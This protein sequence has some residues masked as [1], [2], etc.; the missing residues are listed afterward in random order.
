MSCTSFFEDLL[1]Y[2]LPLASAGG[3]SSW[4]FDNFKYFTLEL[5]VVTIAVFVRAEK[6]EEIGKLLF[7]PYFFQNPF[8][9][10]ADPMVSFVRLMDDLGSIRAPL[11]PVTYSPASSAA[12]C[13]AVRPVPPILQ[14]PGKLGH[15]RT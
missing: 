4:E 2:R 5:F 1:P 10:R 9:D 3:F 6:F 15:V 12:R 13:V 7:T 11:C 8:G 14:Q